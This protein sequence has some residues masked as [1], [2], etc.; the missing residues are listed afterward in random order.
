MDKRLKA[1]RVASVPIVRECDSWR[2][3]RVRVEAYTRI[4]YA[5]EREMPGFVTMDCEPVSDP[6]LTAAR[7]E[8]LGRALIKAAKIARRRTP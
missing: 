4:K 8:Q 6:M 2:G 1:G 5:G 3:N 7:A